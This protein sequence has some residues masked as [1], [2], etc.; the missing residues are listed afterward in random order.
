MKK[1]KVLEKIE[2]KSETYKKDSKKEE[3]NEEN[4][5][6]KISAEEMNKL[7]KYLK[8]ETEFRGFTDTA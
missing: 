4:S 5:E 1:E 8:N 7:R 2:Q 6:E 3:D